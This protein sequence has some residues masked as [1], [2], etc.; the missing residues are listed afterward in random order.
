[1]NTEEKN[2]I[3]KIGK[4]HW[5]WHYVLDFLGSCSL[6]EKTKNPTEEDLFAVITFLTAE[7]KISKKA[8]CINYQSNEIN[9]QNEFYKA[10]DVTYVRFEDNT[11]KD[12]NENRM[13]NIEKNYGIEIINFGC[14]DFEG[15]SFFGFTLDKENVSILKDKLLI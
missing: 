12:L 7:L 1:M 8:F 9:L 15:N 14:V 2:I 10:I 11:H 5:A 3:L 4:V 6:Y 13:L